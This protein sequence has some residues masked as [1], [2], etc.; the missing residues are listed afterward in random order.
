M[1]PP[2]LYLKKD[3]VGGLL[4]FLATFVV[5][6]ISPVRTVFDSKYSM[7]FSEQLLWHG[8]FS[9]DRHAFP[10]L[11]EKDPAEVLVQGENLTYQ[12]VPVGGRLYYF[13]PPGSSVLSI[14][15]VA[16]MN[17]IGISAVDQG[18]T[19]NPRGESRIEG[20]LA[21]LLMAGLVVIVF[22][23]GRLLLPFDWSLLIAVSTAF[24]TQVWSLAS[25]A[26][27]TQ[28]W[29]IFILGLILW[30]ILRTETKKTRLR[31]VL[32]ATCLSWLYFVR[33]TFS[34]S[35]VVI[36]LYVLIFHRAIFLPFVLTGCG[37][38]GAFIGYSQYHFG[39]VLPL[40]YRVTRLR[41]TNS[42][43]EAL[44][45]HL[46]SPS[47]GL[48]I[49]VPV[50]TFIAYL[51]VRYRSSSRTKLVVMAL[52]VILIHL[53]VVSLVAPWQGGHCY[54]PRLSTDLV[55]WFALLGMLAVEARLRWRDKNPAQ[56]SVFRI[57][58]EL[59]FAVLLLV[60]GITLHGIGAVSRGA[61]LWNVLPTNVDQ[62]SSRLWDW[63]HPQFLGVPRDSATRGRE[64][65][66]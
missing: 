17:A 54:G 2:G 5:F 34:S 1:K 6:I 53:I 11:K 12:L 14:P 26:L 23:M 24:G 58:T 51:L 8:S 57:R 39:D 66:G 46:I 32:L 38:F 61:W 22:R 59:G 52:S 45:G 44:P 3:L 48:L 37:W 25:R 35:I 63:R 40:Y 20:G 31:P 64:P 60:C 16:L 41:F 13:F 21:A 42:F 65:A 9:L 56:D 27:W 15:Y 10:E 30:L 4:I 29:G 28:T 50:L 19:Y 33:P 49:Y 62:D 36:A 55:P 47:R 7:L 18:G 43:W